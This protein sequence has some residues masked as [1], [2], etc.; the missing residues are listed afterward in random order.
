MPLD[1][2]YFT[3]PSG[4]YLLLVQLLFSVC[5]DFLDFAAKREAVPEKF[6]FG[7]AKDFGRSLF[8]CWR[9]S[10]RFRC[11]DRVKIAV[12]MGGQSLKS[13]MWLVRDR[14]CQVTLNLTSKV[15]R[16]VSIRGMTQLSSEQLAI[17][18]QLAGM[19]YTA[20]C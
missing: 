6:R 20:S 2:L 9:L 16:K 3:F 19:K 15:L 13:W 1:C 18:M 4:V 11:V 5:C 10:D 8:R 14:Q 12:T 17:L 7:N